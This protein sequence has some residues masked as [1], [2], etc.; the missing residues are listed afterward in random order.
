MFLEVAPAVTLLTSLSTSR[1]VTPSSYVVMSSTLVPVGGPGLPCGS[2]RSMTAETAGLGRGKTPGLSP[3]MDTT[4]TAPSASSWPAARAPLMN[5]SF[6][7]PQP[8][9]WSPGRQGA[10]G[11]TPRQTSRQQRSIARSSS[12][13]W[14]GRRTKWFYRT[15]STQRRGWSAREKTSGWSTSL[16]AA[17]MSRRGPSCRSPSARTGCCWRSCESSSEET[18]LQSYKAKKL[19]RSFLDYQQKTHKN[20][21]A[22]LLWGHVNATEEVYTSWVF[23]RLTVPVCMSGEVG[24]TCKPWFTVRTFLAYCIKYS[25]L[26]YCNF[27]SFILSFMFKQTL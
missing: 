25:V 13:K 15:A 17:T 11:C 18:Y 2:C 12:P 22:L 6:W 10:E 21:F 7:M 20:Y 9:L 1:M 8:S 4:W 19:T 24:L 23:S 3:T 26:I 14:M 27:S 16:K 5:Q